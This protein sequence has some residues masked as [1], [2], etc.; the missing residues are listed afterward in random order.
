MSQ[1]QN[2]S[3]DENNDVLFSIALTYQGQPFNFT[4]YT[5]SLVVKASSAVLDSSGITFTVSSGLTVVNASAGELTWAYP[6]A[7]TGTA[8]TQWWHIDAVD[9]SGNRTTFI[10]GNLTVQAV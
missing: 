1:W 3:I 5:L 10:K 7:D 9:G 6:H 4:G 2:L 8:G